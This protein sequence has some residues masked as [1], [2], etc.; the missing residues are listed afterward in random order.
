MV[1]QSTAKSN[2]L[3][4]STQTQSGLFG[5]ALNHNKEISYNE[6]SYRIFLESC[7]GSRSVCTIIIR[8]LQ[9]MKSRNFF[10]S[11]KKSNCLV[12]THSVCVFDF[13]SDFYSFL[14]SYQ[15]LRRCHCCC[16]CCLSMRRVET[17]F[18]YIINIIESRFFSLSRCCCC[19]VSWRQFVRLFFL[20]FS[21]SVCCCALCIHIYTLSRLN[22]THRL[23]SLYLCRQIKIVCVDSCF[24]VVTT[25]FSRSLFFFF[26]FAT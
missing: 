24:V 12:A 7:V 22:A 10:F 19:F 5:F 16:C 17:I 26:F 8:F 13:F 20:F 15:I 14:I 1:V 3:N 18:H 21:H 2:D 6:K 11:K 9:F 23:L 25:L 4:E